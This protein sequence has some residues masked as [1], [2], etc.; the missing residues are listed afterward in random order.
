MCG[1]HVPL[2][3]PGAAVLP[4][5]C[6]QA[7]L[8][9]DGSGINRHPCL[10]CTLEFPPR[11]HATGLVTL[12]AAKAFGADQVVVTDLKPSNLELATQVGGTVLYCVTPV[13]SKK[14]R[15]KGT[16]RRC[17]DAVTLL[18]CLLLPLLVLATSWRTLVLPLPLLL[19]LV[20]PE[21]A[22]T[23]STRW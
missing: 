8:N 6:W 2:H 7:W 15:K 1:I 16:A 14:E 11:A 23:S 5:T 9:P 19:L 20:E 4:G 21:E 3:P 22:F 17:S 12:L 10:R 13:Y 18:R